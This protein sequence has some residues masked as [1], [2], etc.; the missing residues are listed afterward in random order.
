VLVASL[1]IEG[2]DNRLPREGHQPQRGRIEFEIFPKPKERQTKSKTI[3]GG[4]SPSYQFAVENY[5]LKWANNFL[6]PTW[7]KQLHSCGFESVLHSLNFVLKP[8]LKHTILAAK[9]ELPLW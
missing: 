9:L 2:R 3:L 7:P 5:S 6:R 4:G 8:I 1:K